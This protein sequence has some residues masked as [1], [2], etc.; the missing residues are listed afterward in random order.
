MS[1]NKP[2]PKSRRTGTQSSVQVEP[3][4]VEPVNTVPVNVEPVNIEP[5]QTEK[6]TKPRAKR[7]SKKATEQTAEVSNVSESLPVVE[8][9]K[10]KK[11]SSKSTIKT[12]EN[13]EP[14]P[15]KQINPGLEMYNKFRHLAV[16]LELTK[17]VKELWDKAKAETSGEGKTRADTYELAVKYLNAKSAEI[18][19][20]DE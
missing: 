8:D 17:H 3:V 11:K 4:N 1:S 18:V 5:V 7:Q 12:D 20:V 14:K 10:P 6:T 9:A 13:G 16:E 19:K 15:K 2:A